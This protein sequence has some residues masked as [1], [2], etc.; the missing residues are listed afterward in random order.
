MSIYRLAGITFLI[1]VLTVGCSGPHGNVR[2]QTGND[3]KVTLADLRDNWID[4]DIYYN[5]R[6]N[7]RTD[8]IMFGPKN[9]GTKLTGD[10]W[11]KIEDQEALDEKI[12]EIQHRYSY[13]RVHLIEGAD[14]QVFGYMYYS[15]YLRATVEIIDER[16]L[17]VGSLPNYGSA[18]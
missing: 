18:P 7:W 17:Y 14:H 10:S 11:I 1:I 12:K 16:T 2:K 15:F 8:A 13:A 4:Y 5:K 9:N 6:S 3:D